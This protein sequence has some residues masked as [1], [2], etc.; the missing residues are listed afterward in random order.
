MVRS[1]RKVQRTSKPAMVHCIVEADE[2]QITQFEELTMGD[3][4]NNWWN[5]DDLTPDN[6]FKKD[7]PAYWAWEGWVAGVK[8][9]REACAELCNR[10]DAENPFIGQARAVAK[11]IHARSDVD[12]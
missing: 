2:R 6:G 1:K 4:F 3:Q 11:A 9:E 5:G 8:A 12:E 7:T 10:F